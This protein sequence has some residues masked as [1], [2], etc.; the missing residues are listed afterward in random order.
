MN[1]IRKRWLKNLRGPRADSQIAGE[2]GAAI[3]GDIQGGIQGT[4]RFGPEVSHFRSF[5]G[6]GS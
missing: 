1:L 2:K 6:V 5:S 4:P 3:N